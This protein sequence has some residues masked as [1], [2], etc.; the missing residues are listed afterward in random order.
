MGSSEPQD[1]L[2]ANRGYKVLVANV[3]FASLATLAVA[4]R[5]FAGRFR[6]A[7]LG[8]DDILAVIALVRERICGIKERA[9]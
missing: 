2:H 9:R 7:G 6:S 3:I 1:D 8:V 5:I 4:L